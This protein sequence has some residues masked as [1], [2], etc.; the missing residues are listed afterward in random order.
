MTKENN[1]SVRRIK[2]IRKLQKEHNKSVKTFWGKMQR[3]MQ[4]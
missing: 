2:L 4:E 1:Q 3:K